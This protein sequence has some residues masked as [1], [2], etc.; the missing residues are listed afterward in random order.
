MKSPIFDRLSKCSLRQFSY[1]PFSQIASLT[2][3]EMQELLNLWPNLERLAIGGLFPSPMAT[4]AVNPLTM[5]TLHITDKHE[6]RIFVLRSLSCML[7][8]GTEE[9]FKWLLSGSQPL[10]YHLDLHGRSDRRAYPP[11][12][13]LGLSL[14]PSNFPAL[15]YLHM[16]AFYHDLVTQALMLPTLTTLELVYVDAAVFNVLFPTKVTSL[17]SSMLSR[18][19]L[20]TSLGETAGTTYSL[21]A[22][23]WPDVITCSLMVGSYPK[24]RHLD[25]DLNPMPIFIDEVNLQAYCSTRGL[26][27]S[28]RKPVK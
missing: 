11:E 12:A 6:P 26:Q 25:L 23:V 20:Y 7:F 16:P 27:V 8:S 24:L 17:K 21:G 19:S 14:T 18:I 15:G 1:N 5:E 3:E 22:S 9:F 28:V 13:S 4:I 10:L 2:A